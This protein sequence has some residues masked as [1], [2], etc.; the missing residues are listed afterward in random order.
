VACMRE[1]RNLYRVLVGRPEGKR[2]LER[3]RHWGGWAKMELCVISWGTGAERIHLAQH[4]DPW[5]A[6]VNAA[7]NLRVQAPMS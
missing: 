1:G 2:S 7:M 4:R 6:L 3:Q 5:H